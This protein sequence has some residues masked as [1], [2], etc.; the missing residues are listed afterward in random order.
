MLLDKNIV[1]YLINISDLTT[2]LKVVKSKKTII[3][4]W[5]KNKKW[6]QNLKNKNKLSKKVSWCK[7]FYSRKNIEGFFNN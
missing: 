2:K 1:Q 6:S 3:T 4:N 5:K 7:T